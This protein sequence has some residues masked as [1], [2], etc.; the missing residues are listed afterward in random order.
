MSGKVNKCKGLLA[1]QAKMFLKCR[2]GIRENSIKLLQNASFFASTQTEIS[3]RANFSPPDTPAGVEGGAENNAYSSINVHIDVF[4][5][6]AG[7]NTC[8]RSR[9][10]QRK[11]RDSLFRGA[12]IPTSSVHAASRKRRKAQNIVR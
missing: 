3:G 8:H 2:I 11:Q 1:Q 9:A 7:E 5:G 12:D 6:A 10:A 4:V